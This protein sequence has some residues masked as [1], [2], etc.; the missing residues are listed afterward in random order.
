LLEEHH[1]GEGVDVEK[2]Y[3]PAALR[4]SLG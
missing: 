2:R 3:G 1:Y 4:E